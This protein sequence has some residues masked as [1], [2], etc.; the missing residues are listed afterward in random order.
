MNLFW[1]FY[2]ANWEF[3]YC[4]QTSTTYQLNRVEWRLNP[5]TLNILFI[6][7]ILKKYIINLIRT[8]ANM[9]MGKLQNLSR[10]YQAADSAEMRELLGKSLGS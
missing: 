5:S 4:L 2:I 1:T 10:R 3:L 6:F 8:A 9:L 7:F